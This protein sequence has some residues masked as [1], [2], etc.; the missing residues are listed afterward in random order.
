M[1]LMRRAF[2]LALVSAAVTLALSQSPALAVWTQRFVLESAEDLAAGKLKAV[3][4][5]ADGR[6]TRSVAVERIPLPDDVALAYAI[7]RGAE[8]SVYVGT[9][10]QGRVYRIRGSRAELYAETGQLLV[11]SLAWTPQGTLFAGTLPE[12]RLYRVDG[13]G[14]VRE[15]E[16]PRGIEAIWAMAWSVRRRRLFI[17]TGPEGKVYEVDPARGRSTLWWDAP[18]EHVMSLSLAGGSL[19]AGTSDRALVARL[20][21]PDRVEVVHD[22]PGNE[23]T[24]IAARE[25]QLAVAANL[26]K[27]PP[28]GSSGASSKRAK[29]TPQNRRLKNGEGRLYR[30][31]A[32]GRVEEVYRQTSGHF[33]S[34]ALLDD[35]TIYGGSGQEGR[36]VRIPP[37][38]RSAVWLDLEERQVL[39][40]SLDARSP[41]LVT[42]DGAAVYRMLRGPTKSAVWQS[43]VLDAR[44][45]SRW[46]RLSYRGRGALRFQTRSGQ[47]EVP[48]RTWSPWSK[49]LARSG[50]IPSPVG[51]Y[52]Q[53][54][55]TLPTAA[56]ELFSVTANYLPQNQRPRVRDVT[57]TVQAEGSAKQASKAKKRSR[58]VGPAGHVYRVGWTVDNPDSDRLRY[59]LSFRRESQRVWR[60][61]LK[62]GEELTDKHYDWDTQSVPDGYYIVRV[63]AS[64]ELDNPASLALRASAESLPQRVDNHPPRIERLRFSGRR[65]TGRAVDDL[66]PLRRLAY[67]VDG[68][69]FRPLFPADGL[70]DSADEPF[71][72]PLSQ[73]GRGRHIVAVR[74]IDESGNVASR[75]AEVSLPR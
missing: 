54:R 72:V 2:A 68:Q 58:E 71:V 38:G 62:P 27:A 55:A 8:G 52:L 37:E 3:A 46:G 40:L 57:L 44:F 41:M 32:D 16:R 61:M 67:A 34:V 43:K 73:L 26:F 53:L 45:A 49:A 6:V 4:V 65:L 24:A 29:R 63:I 28:S 30:V 66:G 31:D 12:G 10:N 39:G 13:P 48:D 60:D 47:T 22:F 14:S 1:R 74:A 36:V 18:A 15:I 21:G 69:A 5:H 75:E 70:L 56:S 20:R 42:G 11:T 25:N 33:A 51:R 9:G 23:V 19:Y 17:G 50:V 64:D 35:G 7:E 59:R